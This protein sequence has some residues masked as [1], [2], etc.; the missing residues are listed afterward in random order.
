MN[1]YLNL[2]TTDLLEIIMSY[3]VDLYEIDLIIVENKLKKIGCKISGLEINYFTYLHYYNVLYKKCFYC[4]NYYLFSKFKYKNVVLIKDYDINYDN[5]IN[6][7]GKYY[8]SKPLQN[9]LLLDILICSNDAISITGDY[10]HNCLEG[11]E[12]IENSE[13]LDKYKIMYINPKYVYIRLSMNS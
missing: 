12:Y 1:T 11:F 2:L 5:S 13:L 4:I 7:V 10:Y 8:I 9:P 3:V 6:M